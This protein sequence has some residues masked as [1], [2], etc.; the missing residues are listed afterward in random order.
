MKLRITRV[1]AMSV[2]V[3]ALPLFGFWIGFRE[4]AEVGIMLDAVP[5]G[6]ISLFHLSK[7]DQGA[8]KST[9]TALESDVDLALIWAHRIEEHPLAP[10]MGPLLGLEPLSKESLERLANYRKAHPSPLRA[11]VLALEPMPGSAEAAAIRAD[12]L[13]GARENDQIVSLMVAKYASQQGASK[14]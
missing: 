3:V 2:V 13:K 6:G 8:T 10:V 4:G 14:R 5:R 1:L 11:E 9:V 7:T 12:L